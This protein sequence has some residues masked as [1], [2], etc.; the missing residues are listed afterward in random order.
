M[1]VMAHYNEQS[2]HSWLGLDIL[3]NLC[4]NSIV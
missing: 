4:Q 3:I 2:G 1:A